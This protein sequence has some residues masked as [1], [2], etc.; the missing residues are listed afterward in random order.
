M[1]TNREKHRN[2]TVVNNFEMNN[3][4]P[5]YPSPNDDNDNN[6]I[7]LN[8]CY[9]DELERSDDDYYSSDSNLYG[10]TEVQHLRNYVD[11]VKEEADYSNHL[12]STHYHEIPLDI[13]NEEEWN[14]YNTA[15]AA[16][17][18]S[19]NAAVDSSPISLNNNMGNTLIRRKSLNKVSK[20][21]DNSEVLEMFHTGFI[22]IK[23]CYLLYN[24]FNIIT[25]RFICFFYPILITSMVEEVDQKRK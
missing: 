16:V 11:V 1:S 6:N 12:I 13:N 2:T 18:S 19:A 17:D 9:D 25:I 5:Y 24:I 7:D 8:H 15:N 10:N 23:V 14:N 3:T 20:I 21:L 22:A 4:V